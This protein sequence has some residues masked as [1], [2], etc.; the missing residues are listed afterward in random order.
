M[1]KLSVNEIKKAY[2]VAIEGKI[3]ENDDEKYIT[4]KTAVEV[5]F[6][7]LFPEYGKGYLIGEKEIIIPLS[8]NYLF[9]YSAA[10]DEKN[11]VLISIDREKDGV[12][13]IENFY[14]GDYEEYDFNSFVKT[15]A[16]KEFSENNA[17]FIKNLT[18]A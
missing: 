12:I 10:K 6:K 3:P 17:K 14:T 16:E 11:A 5:N 1:K 2:S 18:F 9:G 8:L 4:L 15:F 7:G 13:L